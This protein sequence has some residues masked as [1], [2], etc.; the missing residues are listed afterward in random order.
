MPR[1]GHNMIFPR[2]AVCECGRGYRCA[3]QHQWLYH[4]CPDCQAAYQRSRSLAGP[5]DPVPAVPSPEHVY[6][7]A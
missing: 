4:G 3:S 7:M 5:P 2:W 1:T 6:R